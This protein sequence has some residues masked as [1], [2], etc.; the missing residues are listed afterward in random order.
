MCSRIAGL[1]T[2][3]VVLS[4]PNAFGEPITIG[5]VG[6]LNEFPFGR[7]TYVGEYQQIY[8]ARSFGDPF[9]ITQI[10]FQT[11]TVSPH[12]LI[13]TFNLSLGTTAASPMALTKDC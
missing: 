3:V 12:P 11:G 6:G 9:N 7:I 4:G 2:I 5:G 1:A 10:S 13:S 8:A